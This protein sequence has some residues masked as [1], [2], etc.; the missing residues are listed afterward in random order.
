MPFNFENL[1]QQIQGGVGQAGGQGQ[2][3]QVPTLGND[4]GIFGGS[5]SFLQTLLRQQSTGTDPAVTAAQAAGRSSIGRSTDR[6]L[7]AIREGQSS[8]GF[9]GGGANIINEL[10]GGQQQA[11]GNLE[12]NLAGQQTAFNQN[13]M[14]NLLRQTMFQG[15]QSAGQRDFTQGQFEF[16]E[17]MAFNREQLAEMRRQF[18]ESQPGFLDDL[19]GVIGTVGGSALGGLTGGLFGGGSASAAG[20]R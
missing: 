12:A 7:R 6:G 2:N 17:N 20:G 3:Q 9:R 5:N 11:L 8:S 1:I 13:A 10:F 15:G 19:F 14:H 16:G 18:D 4:P